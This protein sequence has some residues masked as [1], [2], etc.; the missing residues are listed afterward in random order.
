MLK[1]IPLPPKTCSSLL[2]KPRG[3]STALKIGENNKNMF[4]KNI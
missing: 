2:S 1:T 4:P 3:G